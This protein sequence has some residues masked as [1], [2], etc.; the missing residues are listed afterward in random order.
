MENHA[1]LTLRELF[2]RTGFSSPASSP[3]SSP[4][5]SPLSN[6]AGSPLSN[7]ASSPLSNL[8][9]SPLSNLAGSSPSTP[10]GSQPSSPAGL[11][12]REDSAEGSQ[13]RKDSGMRSSGKSTSSVG[14]ALKEILGIIGGGKIKNWKDIQ[15]G[16]NPYDEQEKKWDKNPII[17]KYLDPDKQKSSEQKPPMMK[18]LNMT[19]PMFADYVITENPQYYSFR[20]PEQR[21]APQAGNPP[22]NPHTAPDPAEAT[23]GRAHSLPADYP[24]PADPVNPPA[25]MNPE[26]IPGA[27]GEGPNGSGHP[28]NSGPVNPQIDD[29]NR[30]NAELQ[31]QV[32]NTT[33]KALVAGVAGIGVGVAVGFIIEK[34]TGA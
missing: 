18:P 3:L 13:S 30:Q 21:S 9:G 26:R 28:E 27:A 14:S 4:A 33:T 11:A 17:A 31:K 12:M 15:T 1:G 8:A 2:D 6:P 34:E 7:L 20:K 29:L 10:A 5:S 24:V 16:L 25:W 23:V 32:K 22:R 19:N